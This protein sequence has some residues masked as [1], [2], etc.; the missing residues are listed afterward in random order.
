MAAG[1][2]LTYIDITSQVHLRLEIA[3]AE[4]QAQVRA[5][6]ESVPHLMWTGNADGDIEYLNPQWL[7]YTG[8]DEAQQLRLG[9]LQQVHAW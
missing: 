1:L 2:V 5:I 9:W 6:V 7:S 3:R 4:A 8:V